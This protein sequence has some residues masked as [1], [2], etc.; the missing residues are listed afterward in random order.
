[1]RAYLSIQQT[2]FG[3]RLRIEIDVPDGCEQSLVPTLILQPLV[4]NAIRHGA[5]ARPGRRSWSCARAV[6]AKGS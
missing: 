1:L 2:R 6:T 3:D 4:E 5:H